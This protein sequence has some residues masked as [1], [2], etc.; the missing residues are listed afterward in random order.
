M[1]D[2]SYKAII[3][4]MASQRNGASP[5]LFNR[6]V[7]H[8]TNSQF[9][10]CDQKS[11]L[12]QA[13]ALMNRHK[14]SCILIKDEQ[15]KFVGIVTDRDFREKVV[16]GGLDLSTPVSEV[17]SSPLIT[18]PANSPAFEAILLMVQKNI[19]HLA[20]TD[21]R[22]NVIG[23]TSNKRLMMAQGQSPVL[24]IRDIQEASAPEALFSKH[25]QIP[26]L[27]KDLVQGGGKAD[28]L[29]RM[30]T[31]ISDA[32]LLRLIEF[33]L[34]KHGP[35]PVNFVFMIMG[36]EG[37]KEQTLK[38][39]QDNAI[40]YEDVPQK[41]EK[42]TRSYF[43]K[44]A[45]TVCGWLDKAGY[46][47]CKGEVMAQNP[48]WCQPLSVWKE[49]FRTWVHTPEPMAVMHSTIFF[50]FKSGYGDSSIT[51]ELRGYLFELLDNRAGLFFYH[52]A[53][54]AL[55]L[56]PPLGFFRNFVVESRGEHRDSFDIKKAM[57]PIVDF[58]RSY[59]L[60]NKIEATNTLERLSQLYWT[61]VLKEQEYN[62]LV[63]SYRYLM[64]IRLVR[65]VTAII[66][67]QH[68]PDNYV[69]PEKLT[70]IEQKMLKEIFQLVS[71]YQKKLSMHFTGSV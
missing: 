49:Y 30:I 43:L 42:E 67:E 41:A 44:F 10:Y 24:L 36:S 55:K 17:M 45:K 5:P 58:A 64:Q 60:E 57:T 9:A 1:V 28:H 12:Q 27:V 56:K 2:K 32:I 53:N 18:I 40:I 15:D 20:V 35:P 7:A 38:T 51:E 71:D 68:P 21:N 6:Q 14:Q 70:H 22:G 16:A 54:N 46:S 25:E 37:R 63:Q 4:K 50:D 65:Q 29:N 19:K 69:N 26:I 66:D 59:A 47:Y 11:S 34:E 13:A 3:A 48:K 8:I 31:A 33:A 23:V 61:G 62:E 52:L 39:D